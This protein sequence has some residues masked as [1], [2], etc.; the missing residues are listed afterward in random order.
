MVGIGAA[1]IVVV[2]IFGPAESARSFRAEGEPRPIPS[3]Q[4][5]PVTGEEFEGILVGRRG[6]PVV[7]N[8][9]ASWC[10]P[11][12]AEMPLLARAARAHADVAVLGVAAR[13]D[14]DAARQ[15]LDEVGVDYPS[16][17]DASGDI[18]ELLGV[19]GFP[20]TYFFAADGTL[21]RTILG[22]VT[23]PQLAAELEELTG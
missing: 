10:A 11:C 16:V 13:D 15:F 17:F 14:P 8:I 20:T 23:E 21:V 18:L 2:S 1:A 4:L 9:W 12:R 3:G 19:R 7:V 22:G 5:T 6:R